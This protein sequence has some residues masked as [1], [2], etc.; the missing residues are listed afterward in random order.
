M[1]F[2]SEFSVSQRGF[3]FR[4]PIGHGSA[5]LS[6]ARLRDRLY[7]YGVERLAESFRLRCLG[8]LLLRSDGLF[9]HSSECPSESVL[10]LVQSPLVPVILYMDLLENHSLLV[11]L[12]GEHIVWSKLLFP[13]GFFVLDMYW[14][15]DFPDQEGAEW[16]SV[17]VELDLSRGHDPHILPLDEYVCEMDP[18]DRSNCLRRIFWRGL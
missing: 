1:W 17:G 15:E 14:F 4:S 8:E 13:C 5:R 10:Q 12:V 16:W 2:Y 7:C 18:A 9:V 3:H 6:A 11:D